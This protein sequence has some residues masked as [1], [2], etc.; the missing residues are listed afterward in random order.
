MNGGYIFECWPGT[1]LLKSWATIDD[2][3]NTPEGWYFMALE[4]GPPGQAVES[5]A[6][7]ESD[8]ITMLDAKQRQATLQIS[9]LQSRIDAINYLINTSNPDHADYLVPDD[10]DYMEP[11]EAELEELQVRKAQL[12][13]W[14]IYRGKLGRV[15][16]LPG[17]YQNPAWP[18]APTP[19]TSEMSESVP[20]TA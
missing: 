15:T 5:P 8:A 1:E 3:M 10:P 13:S 6:K 12:K 11:T 9:A 17:W 18:V 19:Y 2:Q 16:T 7:Q 4:A 20:E 14:N